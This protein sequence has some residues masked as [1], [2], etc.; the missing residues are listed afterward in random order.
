MGVCSTTTIIQLTEN[1][2]SQPL[3]PS[4]PFITPRSN[5]VGKE[6]NKLMA[7]LYVHCVQ[8]LVENADDYCASPTPNFESVKH[9]F[10]DL[11]QH[12]QSV[13]PDFEDLVQHL[14]SA[15]PDFESLVQMLQSVEHNFEDFVQ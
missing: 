15:E 4:T 9:D 8:L 1:K 14:Q 7:E 11:I 13:E 2:L 10:E 3:K 5:S 12:P 6:Q